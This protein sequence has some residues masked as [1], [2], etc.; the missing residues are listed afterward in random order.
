[1]SE[2]LTYSGSNF[3][4]QR[5][6]YSLISGRGVKIIDIR[7]KDENPGIRD[8]E[9]KLFKLIDQITNGVKITINETGTVVN[10]EPG[11]LIGGS[12]SFDCGTERS[13][14]YFLEILVILGS[15]CKRPINAKLTGITNKYD[16]LSCDAIRTTWLPVFKKFILND[17]NLEIKVIKRGFYPLGGG[18][19]TF[20]APITKVIRPVQVPKVGKV[21]KIRGLAYTCRVNSSFANRMIDKAKEKLR[22]YIADVYITVDQRKGESGGN[23]NGYGIFLTAETTDGVF[24]H[25]ECM[26]KPQSD[27]DNQVVPEDLGNIAAERLLDEIYKGGAMDSSALHLASTFMT[28]TSRNASKYL[29]GTLTQNSVYALRNLKDFFGIT[30]SFSQNKENE[31]INAGS[32]EKLIATCIGC[33]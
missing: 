26:S 23:S 2:Q 18:L 27:V 33:C 14:S 13:I 32:K 29:F 28:L 6:A 19:V 7:Y 24:Y 31:D 3:L 9:K 30:F 4:R 11:V 16:E 22:G 1:M 15:F 21:C 12:I 8:F 17:E 20:K 5:L 25:G 10:F